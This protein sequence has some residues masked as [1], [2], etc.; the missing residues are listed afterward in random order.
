MA[1]ADKPKRK[2]RHH[3]PHQLLTRPV[4]IPTCAGDIVIDT[5]LDGTIPRVRIDL[6]AEVVPVQKKG[7][8][9]S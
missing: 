5:V 3:T 8:G 6:P 2:R 7:E 1:E 4:T 9:R